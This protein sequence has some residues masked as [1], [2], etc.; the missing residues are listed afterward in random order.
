D[1]TLRMT[2]TTAVAL[3]TGRRTADEAFRRGDVHFTGDLRRLQELT[4]ALAAIGGA[5]GAV[6]DRT[7]Y[8]VSG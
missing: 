2:Y 8:P 3:A 5:V 6:H 7:T 4:Q 1:A